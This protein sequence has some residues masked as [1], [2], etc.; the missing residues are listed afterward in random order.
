VIQLGKKNKMTIVKSVDFGL[1]LDGEELGEILMPKRYASS[2]MNIGDEI[3]V[4]VYLD[5]EE[6]YL[7]TTEE[8]YGVVGQVAFL[9]V[10]KVENVGAFLDWGL[11]KELMVPFSEQKVK[12]IEGR[13]YVVYIYIDKLTD[14][15]T[16]SMKLE[17][18]LDKENPEYSIGEEVD[19]MIWTGT[20]IGYKVIINHTHLGI[21]YKDEIFKRINTG[22]KSKGFIKKI[23]EDGKIDVSLER[24]GYEKIDAKSDKIIALLE[25]SGGFLPYNDKTDPEVIYN[26]FGV[27]KKVFKQSLGNLFKQRLIEINEKGIT[28]SKDK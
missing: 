12:M 10:N 27:S 6:R 7:A 8:P 28:L 22:D 11:S 23:R 1:Y 21:L 5:G 26:I 2:S 24:A 17:K 14:R 13:Y 18:Y 19:L 16:G 25:K 9:K 4:M 20:E 3:E 15:I